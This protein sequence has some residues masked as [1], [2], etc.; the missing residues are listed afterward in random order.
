M[1]GYP[2]LQTGTSNETTWEY[3]TFW[4]GCSWNSRPEKYSSNLCGKRLLG[5]LITA[6]MIDGIAKEL[7]N[8]VIDISPEIEERRGLVK[9]MREKVKKQN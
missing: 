9:Q 2:P 8:I 3:K 4:R 6:K 1:Y 7:G 5:K